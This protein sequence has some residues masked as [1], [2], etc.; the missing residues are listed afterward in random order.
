M[1]ENI[2]FIKIISK[3]LVIK[4]NTFIIYFKFLSLLYDLNNIFA[5][6]YV[7]PFMTH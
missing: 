2:S 6:K 1:I 3:S 4:I 5:L 7:L